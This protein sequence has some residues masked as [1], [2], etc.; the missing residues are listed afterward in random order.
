M[1]TT[2]SIGEMSKLHHTTIQT[3]RY[4]DEIG[5]F[6]PSHVDEKSGYRYYSTEQFEQLNTIHYLKDLGFSL[7]EIKAH[8]EHRSIDGFLDLLQKQ[9][10]NTEVKIRELQRVRA[11][12][13]H[14]MNEIVQA[15]KINRL[16][17][18]TIRE[19]KERKI[20]KLK[21]N[22]TSEPSL[23]VALRRLENMSPAR[24]SIFIGGVG[25]TIDKEQVKN[26]R[27][28]EY[29]S[30]FILCEDHITDHE[31]AA[32]F[33]EGTYACIYFRGDR[34]ASPDYY[35]ILLDGIHKKRLQIAGDSIE[36]TLID[37]SISRNPEDHLTEIQ[38]P[39]K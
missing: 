18:V 23:E 14:R 7:K 21:E 32:V 29:N 8:L 25:L 4:Y 35:K 16:G 13:E 30:I 3:L 15:R 17:V 9:Q 5:L 39:V 34:S 11:K 31:R 1:K 38:I 22:I 6:V 33:P 2:F 10:N 37:D 20:L 27:F 36:R 26:H 12:F 19:C 24:S 28:D